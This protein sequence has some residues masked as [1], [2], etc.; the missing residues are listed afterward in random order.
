MD[1]F[2]VSARKYR[3]QR[4]EDVVGQQ[5]IANT[6]KLAIR[7]HKLASAYLFCGPRGVGK[8]TCARI[9]AKTINCQNLQPDGEACNECESCRSFNEQRSV[10][11]QE[12][13]AAA[14]NSVEDIR[15]IIDQVR[16]PPQLG[17]YKVIILDEVHMLSQAAGNA[18]LKTL[19][20]PPSYVIFILATTEKQKIMP[21]ILS[22]CQIFDFNRMEIADIVGNLKNV[23]DKEG[24]KY[25]DAALDV[26]AEK[27]DGGMRDALSIFDQVSNYAEGDITYQSVL[28]CI[29]ALDTD[30]Y[31]RI[32]D[33]L[34]KHKVVETM[35]LFNEVVNKGFNGGVFIGGL[36]S[37]LR[38]VM[39]AKDPATIPLLNTGEDLRRRYQEQSKRCSLN[40]LY[41]AIRVC[42]R[43]SNDYRTSY[44]KRL[45]VEIALIQVAQYEAPQSGAQ[46]HDG[47]G[48]KRSA[49]P[50][51]DDGAGSGLGP[52][53][54]LKPLFRHTQP[55]PTAPASS[56]VTSAPSPVAPASSPV[57]PASSPVTPASA[58]G[59]GAPSSVGGVSSTAASASLHVTPAPSPASGAHIL[60]NAAP[61][62]VAP[63]SSS[64]NVTSSA[65]VGAPA[66]V[67]PAFSSAN[68]ASP[69]SA[70]ASST[71]AARPNGKTYARGFGGGVLKQALA[72]ARA[73]AN[74]GYVAQVPTPASPAA[75]A[76]AAAAP[77]VA[78]QPSAVQVLMERLRN[79]TLLTAIKA[80]TNDKEA[81]IPAEIDD[82]D[83]EDGGVEAIGEELALNSA[84]LFTDNQL[85]RQWDD[86]VLNLRALDP[87]MAGKMA[88]MPVHCEKDGVVHV[89]L[90]TELA[91]PAF[92][93]YVS[94]I[95]QFL[96]QRFQ[97]P[98]IRVVTSILPPELVSVITDPQQ[99]LEKMR[100][101]NPDF[102]AA[103]DK[104]GLKI[105]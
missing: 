26:I 34:V 2:I 1:N 8:T 66:S 11:I 71:A 88:A 54:I 105:K 22:R 67:A 83:S 103:V 74:A 44:N 85:R 79:G 27:A 42:D 24:I 51:S 75:Q 70:G 89:E 68:G 60:N 7:N 96:R 80:E 81:D 48:G 6:L 36:A 73:Q 94:F 97:D 9:F 17:K 65:G 57:A 90:H 40:F 76:V 23:A 13:N 25:E 59:V 3:P 100:S 52:A 10:N 4:F 47:D 43:C 56:P 63:A 31:F 28:E 72:Q 18:L 45:S 16:I 37:H 104:L 86:I 62:S 87:P 101:E 50:A 98:K 78:G 53:Q 95:E 29:N 12:L 93:P 19:E 35:L 91:L 30:Y 99:L 14:N 39:M 33:M 32:T 5:S 49:S 21:T 69:L 77:S 92:R 41:Y 55:R 20:E 58:S 46:S 38:N 64:A 102:A 82:N 15:A 61:S 84:P